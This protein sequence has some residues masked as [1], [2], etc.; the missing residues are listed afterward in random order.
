LWYLSIMRTTSLL[1]HFG[2]VIALLSFAALANASSDFPT[3]IPNGT[4]VGC[5]NCHVSVNPVQLN[6]FGNLFP[7]AQQPA[8]VAALWVQFAKADTDG[9]GATNGLELGDPCGTWQPGQTPQRAD[10]IT[11]PSDPADTTTATAPPECAGGGAGG[12]G[13][14]GTGD[15]TGGAVPSTGPGPATPA[16]PVDSGACAIG[17]AGHDA[18][19]VAWLSIAGAVALLSVR[20]RR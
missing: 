6:D 13:S 12:S 7:G 1:A 4:I 20:R 16:A 3:G 14:T 18:P 5:D 11:N 19:C 10:D 2:T 17:A 9:D 15:P 8:D